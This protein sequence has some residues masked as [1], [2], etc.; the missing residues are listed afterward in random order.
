MFVR[1]LALMIC[2]PLSLSAQEEGPMIK[3]IIA[4]HIMPR[5]EVFAAKTE[6]LS[7]A[8]AKDCSAKGAIVPAYHAA[9]DAWIGVSHLR[10]GPT[11]IND[12]AFAL[13]FW[14]DTKGFT[15]KTLTRLITAQDSAVHD[16]EEFKNVSIAGRGFYALEFLLFDPK[17]RTLGDDTYR[18]S[19]IKAVIGDIDANAHAILADWQNNYIQEMTT[20]HEGSIYQTQA[21]ALQEIYKALNTGLQFTSETRIGRPLGTFDRPRATRADARRSGRSLHN[22]AVALAN[23]RD[24]A[25]RLSI[26]DKGVS[27]SFDAGFAQSTALI[28]RLNDPVFAGVSTP[29]G[30]LEVEILQQSIDHIREISIDELGAH[31]GVAAGFNALDGD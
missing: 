4:A 18:C 21:E 19:L 20:P 24:L 31:L 12:R 30:H 1:S 13:A 22:V 25:M 26:N 8:G 16:P 27:N 2:L 15:P 29:Q 17:I 9:F 23:L 28:E 14:P 10:F 6:I 3:S 5:F 11:E 7:N